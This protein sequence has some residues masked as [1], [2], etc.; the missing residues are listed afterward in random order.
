[1]AL[2]KGN[3]FLALLLALA[4]PVWAENRVEGVQLALAATIPG[5]VD[6]ARLNHIFDAAKVRLNSLVGPSSQGGYRKPGRT[7]DTYNPSPGNSY[8]RRP[9]LSPRLVVPSPKPSPAY[10]RTF[11]SLLANTRKTDQF[12]EL[13]LIYARAYR[14]DAR[15]LKAIIA[16]ESEFFSGAVSPKGARGLMQ[17]MPA[18]AEGIGVPADKLY[19]PVFNIRAGAAFLARL[20]ASAWKRYRLKGV[21][22]QDAPLWLKQRIVA[23]YNAGPRAL[24]HDRWFSET[25]RYV[26]KVML[27]YQSRVTDIR[28]DPTSFSSAPQIHFSLTAGTLY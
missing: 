25:R 5:G 9:G 19:D 3:A 16:A 21:R 22:F 11:R 7:Q 26:K 1:M 20:F 14:L 17:V 27:F 23:A 4:G 24:F 8:S 10:R 6:L 12:D 28:R 2:G 15:L 13:I 18:T